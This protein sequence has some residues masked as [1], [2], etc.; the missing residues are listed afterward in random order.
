M[1]QLPAHTKRQVYE[2]LRAM[3]CEVSWNFRAVWLN[4]IDCRSVSLAFLL[5][6]ENEEDRAAI[7]EIA[8]EFEAQQDTG[9]HLTVNVLVSQ[10]SNLEMPHLGYLVYARREA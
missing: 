4:S 3:L 2:L 10:H 8:F 5:A 1:V 9:I 7:K 6:V